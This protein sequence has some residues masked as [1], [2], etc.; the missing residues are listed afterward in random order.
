M[1]MSRFT[2]HEELYVSG[3]LVVCLG[4]E[5][6]GPLCV[7]HRLADSREIDVKSHETDSGDHWFSLSFSSAMKAREAFG[8]VRV[9]YPDSTKTI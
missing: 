3:K 7:L 1:T 2:N 6:R 4:R 5:I 9:L 8:K